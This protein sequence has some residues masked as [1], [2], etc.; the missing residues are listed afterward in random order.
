MIKNDPFS[1]WLGIVCEEVSEGHCV[2]RMRVK[3]QMLNG[4]GILHGGISFSLADSALAFAANGY[5]HHAMSI[6]NSIDYLQP[7]RLG[8]ELLAIASEESRTSRLARYRVEIHGDEGKTIA[9]FRGTVFITDE[10][11]EI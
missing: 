5:G 9:L 6:H 1:A 2:L 7:C 3:K 11:W 4:F 10:K 8:D